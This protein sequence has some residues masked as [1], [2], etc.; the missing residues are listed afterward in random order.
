MAVDAN[1]VCHVMF[2]CRTS[3]RMSMGGGQQTVCMQT[4][5]ACIS[6]SGEVIKFR[7]M[8]VFRP[9]MAQKISRPVARHWIFDMEAATLCWRERL[10]VVMVSCMQFHPRFCSFLAFVVAC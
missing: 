4:A 7:A 10:G 5:S 6:L 3:L 1:A 9:Q 2:Q 8:I